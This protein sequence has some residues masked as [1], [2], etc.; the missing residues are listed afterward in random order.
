MQMFIS[1]KLRQ[2][3]NNSSAGRVAL[4]LL[5]ASSY[6]LTSRP[7]TLRIIRARRMHFGVFWCSEA[8]TAFTSLVWSNL[9][10]KSFFLKAYDE[11]NNKHLE[12]LHLS[13]DL[14]HATNN[15]RDIPQ[16]P[17]INEELCGLML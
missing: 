7:S 8:L 1:I 15:M 16:E 6:R 2:R 4:L 17:C 9:K 3:K 5:R 10:S 11:R 14:V 12:N 13:Q